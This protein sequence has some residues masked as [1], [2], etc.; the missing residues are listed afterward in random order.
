M[1]GQGGSGSTLY[2]DVLQRPTDVNLA[3]TKDYNNI[4][5]NADN[6]Y[7]PFAMNPYWI[8]DHNYATYQDD[9][10]YGNIE[11]TL[12]LSKS[13]KAIGRLGGDFTTSREKYCND[14]WAPASDSWAV[15]NG[16]SGEIGSYSES[17]YIVEPNRC[18]GIIELNKTIGDYSIMPIAGWNY[19]TKDRHHQSVADF[20]VLSFRGGSV[21]KNNTAYRR[22]RQQYQDVVLVG[23]LAQADFGFRDY[24]IY[25]LGTVM[26]VEYTPRR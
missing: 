26:T 20:K 25:L 13:L 15:M 9:R 4:Y 21:L 18:I 24:A 14:V 1:A 23:A 3:D 7:T 22:F 10:V 11:L 17:V 8:V 19:E 12:D 2:G 16:A 5:N 6:F